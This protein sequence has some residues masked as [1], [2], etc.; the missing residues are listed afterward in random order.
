[1]PVEGEERALHGAGA[2]TELLSI[3]DGTIRARQK[4]LDEAA[5]ALTTYRDGTAMRPSS[6]VRACR[7]ATA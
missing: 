4:D 6:A 2:A 3:H 7:S 5:T 1:M